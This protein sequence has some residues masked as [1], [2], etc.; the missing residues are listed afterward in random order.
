[1]ICVCCIGDLLI[2]AFF[3]NLRELS[4]DIC[5]KLTFARI[6]AQYGAETIRT[7]CRYMWADYFCQLPNITVI[8]LSLLALLH[9]IDTWTSSDSIITWGRG[10]WVSFFCQIFLL[11]KMSSI[12]LYSDYYY[13]SL[14]AIFLVKPLCNHLRPAG[15]SGRTTESRDLCVIFWRQTYITRRVPHKWQSYAARVT[16]CKHMFMKIID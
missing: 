11:S 2:S 7:I 16:Q 1:M 10:I 4:P 12:Y 13:L 6:V 14:L 5:W 3:R 8:F 15:I 9:L